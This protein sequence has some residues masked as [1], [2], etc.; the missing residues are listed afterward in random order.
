[1]ERFTGFTI[2]LRLPRDH[3]TKIVATAM[4]RE[5]ASLPDHLCRSIIWNHGTELVEY[6]KIQKALDKTLYF[7]D[8]HLPLTSGTN[9]STFGPFSA[10]RRPGDDCGETQPQAQTQPQP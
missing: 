3:T 9:E 1:M 4:V 2:S 7:Y 5:M 6:A 10:P 8:P